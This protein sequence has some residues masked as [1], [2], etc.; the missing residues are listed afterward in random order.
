METEPTR[1]Q[2]EIYTVGFAR[3]F[4]GRQSNHEKTVTVQQYNKNPKE[5]RSRR[6]GRKVGHA[7]Y[8]IIPG[9]RTKCRNLIYCLK[10]SVR[11]D[12]RRH[13]AQSTWPEWPSFSWSRNDARTA[14]GEGVETERHVDVTGCSSWLVS[15]KPPIMD[16]S[17]RPPSN[18]SP[19]PAPPA[20]KYI[21]SPTDFL[22]G[23]VG[24]RVIVRLT[25]GV[26]YQGQKTFSILTSCL[27]LTISPKQ[28]FFR[29][30]LMSRRIHE[31]RTWANRGVCKWG[32]NKSL[33]RCIC[34]RE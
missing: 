14:L 2:I 10:K 13:N 20:Q 16:T 26:D 33:W 5:L 17:P 23:V 34:S 22:K 15:L 28:N 18:G 19:P 24:K 12:P 32:C 27:F 3:L 4:L 7:K 21:G 30:P 6:Q 11:R 1:E 29:N 31:Y 9:C 25:S 8:W